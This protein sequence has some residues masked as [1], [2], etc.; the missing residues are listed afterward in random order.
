MPEASSRRRGP[1]NRMAEVVYPACCYQCLYL[2][3]L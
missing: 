3:S 1:A 2:L